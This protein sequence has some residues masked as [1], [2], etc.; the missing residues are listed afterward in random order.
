MTYPIELVN[1]CKSFPSADGNTPLQILN[2]INFCL[3]S[4]ESTAI[5]GKSGTGKST[6]L[7][8]CGG[9]DKPTEGSVLFNGTDISKL[10]DAKMSELRN[11]KIGFIF[12]A[13]MLME[14]FTA[15][16]NVMIP[17]QIQGRRESEC[18]PIAQDLLKQL[19][20]EDRMN[21]YPA[22]LSGGEKQRVAIARALINDPDV[23]LADEPTGSLDEENA[24]E[25]EDRLLE[26]V[27]SGNRTLL[28]VTHNMDFARRCDRILVLK[29]H[30]LTEEKASK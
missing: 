15:L 4:N 26:I 2:N 12:Q 9:L 29:N 10:S 6:L 23:I 30:T 16:E 7:Q 8:I 22:Q 21:H 14:D 18:K 1:I 17:A 27:K 5:I 20:L 19:G 24:K 13:N 11:R 25:V 28:L 3:K